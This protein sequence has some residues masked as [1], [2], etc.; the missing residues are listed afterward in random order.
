MSSA[1]ASCL[2]LLAEDNACI[3]LTLQDDLESVGYGV[4]GPFSTCVEALAWLRSA[5]P[6]V[7]VLDV[8]LSDG[9]CCELAREL[10]ERGVPFVVYSGTSRAHCPPEFREVPWIGKPAPHEQVLDAISLLRPMEEQRHG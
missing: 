1:S 6:D 8:L 9:P 2:V 3:G 4:A 7:A 10:K 5:T